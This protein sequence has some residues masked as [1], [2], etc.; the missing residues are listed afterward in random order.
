MRLT[1]R[2]FGQGSLDIR[3]GADNR[4]TPQRKRGNHWNVVYYHF[5]V[6]LRNSLFLLALLSKRGV[7]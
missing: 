4:Q 2:G 5:L 7:L 6:S 3:T 1:V